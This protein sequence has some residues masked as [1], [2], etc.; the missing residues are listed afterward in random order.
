MY[1]KENTCDLVKQKLQNI[2]KLIEQEKSHIISQL[3]CKQQ[4]MNF[5]KSQLDKANSPQY[6]KLVKMLKN[7]NIDPDQVLSIGCADQSINQQDVIQIQRYKI[8]NDKAYYIKACQENLSLKLIVDIIGIQ[9]KQQELKMIIY[10]FLTQVLAFD[11]T[12]NKLHVSSDMLVSKDDVIKAGLPS[13][14]WLKGAATPQIVDSSELFDF[15][16]VTLEGKELTEDM[17][18]L[19]FDDHYFA[20]SSLSMEHKVK[21]VY[22][23]K[24]DYRC[25]QYGGALIDYELEFDIPDCGMT[26]VYW[27]KICGNP[28][29]KRQWLSMDLAYKQYNSTIAQNGDL[30]NQSYFDKD[31]DEFV[32]VVPANQNYTVFYL[33]MDLPEGKVSDDKNESKEFFQALQDDDDSPNTNSDE[34]QILETILKMMPE[35]EIR[36]PVVDADHTYLHPTLSG[37]LANGGIITDERSSLI[38][39]YNCISTG[40]TQIELKIPL[41][42]FRDITLVFKKQCE[43]A[44]QGRSTIKTLFYLCLLI[45]MAFLGYTISQ[46]KISIKNVYERITGQATKHQE[47][48]DEETQF[49]IG[50]LQNMNSGK[51]GSI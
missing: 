33:Y 44:A 37:D 23:I 47:R 6:K 16:Y 20:N 26:K 12:C 24:I 10:V 51:Y 27:K 49:K 38:L 32:F 8:Q 46:K 19:N 7:L 4:E 25:K 39:E 42:Y 18:L 43:I 21:N 31:L 5:Y 34:F 41:E 11:S 28:M 15:L 48:E 1:G 36:T 14:N 45:T 40:E 22:S 50:R 2:V 17:L 9:V 30:V 13:A 35:V 29:V 3:K